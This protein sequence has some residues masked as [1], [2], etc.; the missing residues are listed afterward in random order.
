[1]LENKRKRAFDDNAKERE[2]TGEEKRLDFDRSRERAVAAT[3][4]RRGVERRAAPRRTPARDFTFDA[5]RR[6][7][8]HGKHRLHSQF[9]NNT[10]M[11]DRLTRHNLISHVC[12]VDLVLGSSGLGECARMIHGVLRGSRS[13]LVYD[14][15]IAT[16]TKNTFSADHFAMTDIFTSNKPNVISQRAQRN[17]L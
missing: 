11:S 9:T 7:R 8:S 5:P 16:F 6:K 14:A 13:Y 1:M 10:S 4:S 17:L 15:T 12:S 3:A 2:Q